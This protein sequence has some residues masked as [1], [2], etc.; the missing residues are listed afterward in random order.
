[1][2]LSGQLHAPSALSPGKVPATWP[3]SDLDVVVKKKISAP[4]E[5]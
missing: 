2:E 3:E 1:M 5:N 4:A